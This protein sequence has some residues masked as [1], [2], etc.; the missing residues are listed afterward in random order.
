MVAATAL[1]GLVV[2][3]WQPWLLF[4]RQGFSNDFYDAQA[5]AFWHLRLDV[6]AAV[7]GP[8]GFLIGGRTYLYYG[9]F[10]AVLRMPA[11]L[12]GHWVDGRLVRIS[13]T[14][15]FALSMVGSLRLLRSVARL[16]GRRLGERRE[17]WFIAAIAA[18][19]LLS[20]AGWES[21]YHETELWAF[22]LAILAFSYI[23]DLA[24][25]GALR[26]AALLC[27]ATVLTRSSVGYGVAVALA[28]VHTERRR[29]VVLGAAA[30]PVGMSVLLNL[31]RFGTLFDLPA[32]RQVLSLLDPR[33]AAWFA[34]NGGSFFSFRFLPTTLVQYL[35]PDAVRVERLVPF[36]RFGPLATEYG[37][38]PLEGNTPATSLPVAAPLVFGLAIVGL[39]V[40][41]RRRLGRLVPLLLGSLAATA[42]TLLIGFVAQR[43][44][45]DLLPT[46][47]VPAAVAVAAM[48]SVGRPMRV[49]GGVAI[50]WGAVV[51]VALATWISE[52]K[53]PS[54]TTVRYAI[55]DVFFDGP[56]PGVI[57][58]EPALAV[59][60]DGV[61]A[62]DGPCAGL[63]IAEQGRWVALER[64]DGVRSITFEILEGR[65]SVSTD[66]GQLVIDLDDTARVTWR[67]LDGTEVVSGPIENGQRPARV[68][69]S[70]DPVVD[71]LLVEVDGRVVLGAPAVPDLRTAVLAGPARRVLEPNSVD[72]CTA[73]ARRVGPA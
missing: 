44:L 33:R 35:R 19:P 49:V 60:R 18:T 56:P 61:V 65:T 16:L 20:M 66:A 72:T 21:V 51:A 15:A 23:V 24:M 55:D 36:V 32:D 25:G 9:P 27:L 70:A 7:A 54:F 53:E 4:E 47:V 46:L 69:V 52:L 71:G 13:M 64:A 43:Y 38:Y 63:Y 57:R 41:V 68:V 5:R 37:S 3:R 2:C 22:A 58:L 30:V 40:I 48:G 29:A 12:L 17:T 26:P 1:F 11:V 34:G 10:L 50:A 67:P 28:L 31:A 14:T 45:V 39:A 42:P 62:I 6:P 73:I 8:E 59:P